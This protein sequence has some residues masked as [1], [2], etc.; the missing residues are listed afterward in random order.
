MTM[1]YLLTL[2]IG[3]TSVKTC[4]F[5]ESFKIHGY[6]SEEYELLTPKTGI[7]ELNPETYWMAVKSGIKKAI[8]ES[9]INAMKIGAIT[10]T[11]QG[12]T[13]IPVNEYGKPL[14]NAIVWLDARAEEEASFI[15]ERFSAGDAYAI[16][17]L[18]EMGP[19]CPVC[20]VLWIKKNEKE[21]F[22]KT[23]K[24]LLLEDF[25]VM[26]LTGKFITEKSLMSSTGYFDINR[27]VL[28]DQMLY[29]I[30]IEP[31]KFPEI[32]DCGVK[33][34]G[35]LIDVADDLGV[36]PGIIVS[37][38]AMDQAASAIGAGN[39]AS[40]IVTETTGTALVVAATIDI[41]DY[42]S[43]V[44]LNIIRH[45][46]TGKF[47]ILPYN[48][49]SGIILKWF[50]DEFCR[51]ETEKCSECGK[52]IYTYMDEM[53][54]VVPALSNGLLLLPHFAGML[55]PEI[56][57]SVRGVFFG[58]GLDSQ[59]PHFIRSILEGTAFMLRQNLELLSA[60]GVTTLEIRSLGGGSK[61]SL[62]SQIKADVCNIIVHTM[63]FEE[64]T[65]LG[66]AIL[67][68]VAAGIYGSAEEACRFIRIKKS[69]ISGGINAGVYDKGFE[70]YK[71]LYQCLKVIFD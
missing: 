2:D 45:G 39:I 32:L 22:D 23:Y 10:I 48:Q 30:G 7:V 20:K 52:S 21:I 1:G 27:E 54:G 53:A 40:G 28:W 31:E 35:I 18:P 64:S 60:L 47:L 70:K 65:S 69:Y 3:T 46:I 25:I 12:E 44:R 36:N 16:T 8:E 26:K 34:G 19:A 67:G 14:R 37:T 11:T 56:N 68:S 33:A 59:K 50:K 41:P 49:T 66:A 6:S 51:I 43:S 24:F 13:L 42:L 62:W 17:G 15:N 58:I 9:G 57:P 4:I 29:C 61:S 63:E 71:K 38:G 55:T 5:N